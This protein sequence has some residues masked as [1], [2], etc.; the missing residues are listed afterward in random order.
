MKA[1]DRY[2]ESNK[3]EISKLNNLVFQGTKTLTPK[4]QSEIVLKG[5]VDADGRI[6]LVASQLKQIGSEVYR[7]SVHLQAFT[8][9]DGK[10][11]LMREV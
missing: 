11:V 1:I 2:V 9:D 6:T 5:N 4:G 7:R 3:E 10:I 8:D